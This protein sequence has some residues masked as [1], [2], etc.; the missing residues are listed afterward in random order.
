M[1]WLLVVACDSTPS[2]A[3]R[4]AAAWEGARV[5]DCVALGDLRATCELGLVEAARPEDL[6]ALCGRL[7]EG[8]AGADEC[9]FRIAERMIVADQVDQAL[10]ACVKSG[11]YAKDCARHL[12]QQ[13]FRRDP[14]AGRALLPRLR[15]A[16]P[17][18]AAAFEPTAPNIRAQEWKLELRDREDLSATT[19][20]GDDV[21]A[22]VL[23]EVVMDRWQAAATGADGS[24]WC[25]LAAAG[26]D[27]GAAEALL[28]VWLRVPA[29]HEADRAEGLR[30]G[31]AGP[32]QGGAGP[33][34]KRSDGRRMKPR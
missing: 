34:G 24:K 4:L 11:R 22:K 12:W 5:D 32:G 20:A 23:G 10:T 6:A 14:A 15:E 17:E 7:L 33:A 18:H 28:S 31:C 1:I 30:R 13:T 26:A 25:G 9:W 8:G 27:P 29:G 3:E 2:R 16:L 21:C 19:C